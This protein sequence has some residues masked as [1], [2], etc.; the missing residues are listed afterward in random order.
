M[1]EV[2]L[3][4][5]DEFVQMEIDAVSDLIIKG[6]FETEMAEGMSTEASV[7]RAEHERTPK[8]DGLISNML[9]P[10][11]KRKQYF[12]HQIAKTSKTLTINI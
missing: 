2:K 3:T 1:P 6:V 4:Y 5:H 7:S 10:P 12:S 8:S 11:K 9:L